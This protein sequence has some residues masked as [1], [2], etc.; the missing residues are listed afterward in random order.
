MRRFIWPPVI[1]FSA[2]LAGLLVNSSYNAPIRLLFTLWFLLVCPGMAFIQLFQLKEILAEWVLAIGLSIALDVLVSEIAVINRW[3]S[4]QG[5]VGVLIGLC[6]VGAGLQLGV[7]VL[8]RKQVPNEF[9][10]NP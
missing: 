10:R 8:K 7:S 4:L 6:L 5:M 1:L 9:D 2:F 3:W